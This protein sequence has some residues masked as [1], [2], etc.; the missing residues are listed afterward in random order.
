MSEKEV[1][2]RIE[3]LKREGLL[4]QLAAQFDAEPSATARA[5]WRRKSILKKSTTRL[6]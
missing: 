1:I 5:S 2:K 4:R 6:R 3:R